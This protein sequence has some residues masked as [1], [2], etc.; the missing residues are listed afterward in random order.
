MSGGGEGALAGVVPVAPSRECI[1]CGFDVVGLGLHAMCP[2]CELP[3]RKTCERWMLREDVGRG[4]RFVW[5]AWF[6]LAGVVL[7]VVLI[8]FMIFADIF[9]SQWPWLYDLKYMMNPLAFALIFFWTVST[10]FASSLMLLASAA[11]APWWVCAGGMLG[12]L[13]PVIWFSISESGIR[14]SQYGSTFRSTGSIMLGVAIV[15]FSMAFA[16]SLRGV[17]GACDRYSA[18]ASTKRMYWVTKFWCGFGVVPTFGG[19][20]LM[21]AVSYFGFSSAIFVVGRPLLLFSVMVLLPATVAI[22]V[23][24]IVNWVRVLRAVRR[25]MEFG[26]YAELK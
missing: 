13:L 9:G 12:A 6:V 2:E 20:L 21:G 11:R 18:I 22:V 25:E 7:P 10:C 16:R 1:G 23:Y 19:L 5:S 15:L 24:A 17:A 8:G 14:S 3:V 26:C 4:R